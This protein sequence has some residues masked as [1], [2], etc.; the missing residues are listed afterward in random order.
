MDPDEGL[1]G[2]VNEP[3]LTESIRVEKDNGKL[4]VSSSFYTVNSR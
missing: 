2:K 1:R 3:N 4:M